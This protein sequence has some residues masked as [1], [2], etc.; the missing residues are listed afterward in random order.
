MNIVVFGVREDRDT[1]V[2]RKFVLEA[3]EHVAGR[4]VETNDM[5]GV[6]RFVVG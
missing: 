3:L 5:F 2:W 1:S 6:G 4:T